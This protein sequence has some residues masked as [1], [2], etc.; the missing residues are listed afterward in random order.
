MD[1]DVAVLGGGPGGYPAAI[2]AAQLGL[3]VALI[4]QGEL[5][6]TCLNVGCIPTKAWVQSAHALKD[7]HHAFP[8]L[9]VIVGE[10]VV[11]FAQV[12]V[13]KG[14]IVTTMV[15]GVGQFDKRLHRLADAHQC[16]PFADFG[17]QLFKCFNLS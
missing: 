10:P 2:R 9:G 17:R 13:N 3:S 7:A 4:E 11:D 5:G 1:V 14:Q 6:G 16:Y 8:Q 12:Q 15:S